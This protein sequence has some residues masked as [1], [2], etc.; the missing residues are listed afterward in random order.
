MSFDSLLLKP[1]YLD[2][3]YDFEADDFLFSGRPKFFSSKLVFLK[4]TEP[5]DF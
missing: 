4:P 1:P 3:D 5:G 2:F